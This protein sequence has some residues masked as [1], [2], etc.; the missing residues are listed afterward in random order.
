[1]DSESFELWFETR[2]RE[3]VRR[4]VREQG[5]RRRKCERVDNGRAGGC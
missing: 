4:R 1:M 5:S 3:R 2:V